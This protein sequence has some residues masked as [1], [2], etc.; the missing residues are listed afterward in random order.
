MP[1]GA[2]AG[3]AI[4]LSPRLPWLLMLVPVAAALRLVC[5]LLD[6]A[7][8]RRTGRVHARGELYNELGDR[9]ADVLMLAPVAF[10]PGAIGTA[11]WV[12]VVLALLA[13]FTSVATR[14]AGGPR[15]YRGLLSKP[16]RM[17]LVSVFAVA[18]LFLGPDAWAP[19]GPLLVVGTGL[20]LAERVLVALR[21]LE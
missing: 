15:S 5:N 18:V 21:E 11:V 19:F 16:G 8:A 4:L 2:V 20:T 6:G 1:I 17:V 13:S 3:A 10:V 7:L 9:T 12:G 14:A